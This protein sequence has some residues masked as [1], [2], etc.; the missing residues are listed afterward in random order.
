MSD[1]LV[2]KPVLYADDDENDQF[3]MERAFEVLGLDQPLMLVSD[4]KLAVDYLAGREPYANRSLHP[5]PTLVLLDLSM[6]GKSGFDVLQWIR[7]SRS[8]PNASCHFD[9]V[10]SG[11]RHPPR[12]FHRCHRIPRQTW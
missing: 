12:L 7:S 9:L 11:E 3:L 6:P 5:I 2:R 4:G 1:S 10:K 8:W